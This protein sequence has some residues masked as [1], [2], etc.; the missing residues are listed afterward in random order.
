MIQ[1]DSSK[2]I[3]FTSYQ[4]LVIAIIALLQFTVVL[5]FMILS[6]LGDFLMKSLDINPS[7]FGM[8]VSAYAFSAGIS[9][10]LAAGFADRF[11]RKK[12]LVF[13][14]TGFIVGTFFCAIA[15]NFWSLLAARIVTGLF[16]GVIGAVSMAIITDLFALN[17][18]GRVMG[19]VQMGFA[20]SQ[21]LGIPTGLFFASRWGWHSAFFMIV[22]V[23]LLLLLL[24]YFKMKPV[25]EH[26]KLQTKQNAL[27]HLLGTVAKKDYRIG[28][29][30]TSFLSI[31]GFMMMP[32]G[33]AFAINNLKIPQDKIFI[34]FLFTGVSSLLIMPVVGKLSDRFDKFKVFTGG[35][36]AAIIMILI[37]TNLGPTPIWQ[38]V[39]LNIL[40]FMGIM[41][42]MIPATTLN[43]AIPEMKDRGAYMSINGSLQQMAGGVAAL[44]AGLIVS[45]PTKTS[46]LEHYNTLGIVVSLVTIICLLLVYRVSQMIKARIQQ[47][48]IN[49]DQVPAMEG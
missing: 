26:L 21:V 31:G 37:Y 15:N 35:S 20:A 27:E 23:A 9:G 34:L 10:L 14:Y 30:A 41:S 2:S 16:G 49:P 32:F 47:N 18:R 42:R 24:M 46:P 48:E 8:V 25:D 36:I 11:D 17:Q 3:P 19:I 4:I 45:Q 40:L 22:I 6:P 7:R 28:F 39:C 43:S 12:I 5:D 29:L 33:S 44:A 1:K 38:V 13:F